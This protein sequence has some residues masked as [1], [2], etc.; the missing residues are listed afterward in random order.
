MYESSIDNI[1]VTFLELTP[2]LLWDLLSLT[3]SL[4]YPVRFCLDTWLVA[5]WLSVWGSIL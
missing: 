5:S 4:G 3:L 2:D 1:P